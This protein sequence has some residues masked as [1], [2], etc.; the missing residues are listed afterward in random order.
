VYSYLK[1]HVVFG[2]FP[3]SNDSA[4]SVQRFTEVYRLVEGVPTCA[5]EVEIT[6]AYIIK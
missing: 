2:N 6:H 3:A 1:V 4:A 5:A